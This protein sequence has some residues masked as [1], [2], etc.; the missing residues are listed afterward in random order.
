[1]AR[2]HLLANQGHDSNDACCATCRGGA[3]CLMPLRG[4]HWSDGRFVSNSLARCATDCGSLRLDARLINGVQD[5]SGH[6]NYIQRHGDTQT[7]TDGATFDGDGDFIVIS[8]FQYATDSVFSIGMWM[9]KEACGHGSTYEYLYSHNNFVGV[10]IASA[11]NSNVNIF[12]GCESSGGGWSTSGG[13]SIVRFNL[14]DRQGDFARFD[15][16][17]HEP[18]QLLSITSLWLHIALV[19]DAGVDTNG[20]AQRSAGVTTYIDGREVPGSAYGFYT[21]SPLEENQANLAYPHPDQMD[22]AMAGF[23][24]AEDI[25]IGARSDLD[26]GRFFTGHLAGLTVSADAL[27]ARQI[28]CIFDSAEQFLPARLTECQGD[29]VSELFVTLTNPTSSTDSS[30]YRRPVSVH[31]AEV[32]FRGAQ[33]DGDG[34]YISIGHFD[35]ASD[36][37]FSISLWMTKEQ[38]TG[39]PYEYLY[40]H[41][42]D[43][44]SQWDHHAYAL[45]MFACENSAGQQ[46]SNLDGSFIRYDLM[47]DN[48]HR[49]TF[50]FAL[51]DAGDFDA[52]THQWLHVILTVSSSAI[53]TYEDGNLVADSEYGYYQ[54]GDHAANVA[55]GHPSDLSHGLTSFNLATDIFVGGRADLNRGRHFKG[56]IALVNVYTRALTGVEAECVFYAGD[57]ALPSDQTDHESSECF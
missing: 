32:S 55:Y 31:G 26:A 10:D 53:K 8:R 20:G 29:V 16:P 52:I 9:V 43:T 28:T 47:D 35:Y 3:Y 2:N 24:L 5:R 42:H 41:Q 18:G 19:V 51:H 56:R 21:Y 14:V 17:L 23:T 39:G 48:S 30:Q 6:N 4:L 25:V 36:A 27:H 12:L 44:G 45:V 49:A 1:M 40:S 15:V 57:A 34:D 7:G 54:G 38:C 46:S 37:V 11:N 50:D 13:G 22:A 33:F